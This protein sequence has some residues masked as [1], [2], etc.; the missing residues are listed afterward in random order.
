MFNLPD[1]ESQPAARSSVLTLVSGLPPAAVCDDIER[2][3]SGHAI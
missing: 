2:I 1:H 3:N